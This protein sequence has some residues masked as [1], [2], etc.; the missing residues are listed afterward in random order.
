[1]TNI[2][3]AAP[4]WIRTSEERDVVF[5]T[6]KTLQSY[7]IPL[8]LVDAGSS[9]TDKK[10]MKE[11][12][13]VFFFEQGQDLTKQ[14]ITTHQE[15]AKRADYIFYVQSDKPDFAKDVV[16]RM[17]AY[18]S[19][20]EE[21]G[22]LI[23]SRTLESLETYPLFQKTQEAFL[24]FF[25]SEYIGISQDFFAGPKIIPAKLIS[26]ADAIT[27]DI[28]WGV[29]SYLYVLAKRLRIPFDFLSCFITAPKDVDEEEKT[30]V[31][32]LL[33]TKWQ[34]EGFLQAQHLSL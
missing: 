17:L 18:Y 23:P 27:G 29:E 6:I 16:P 5:E 12:N 13:N 30:K 26:Y 32:R 31:Y 7:G 3:F 4:S 21:K 34:I 14:L 24:N 22:L 33:G 2:V 19:T 9:D 15:A 1:V 10:I 20:L 25:M 28:G 11:K 8:I